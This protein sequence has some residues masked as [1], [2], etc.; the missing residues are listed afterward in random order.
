[1]SLLIDCHTHINDFPPSEISSVIERAYL[2][3]VEIIISARTTLQSS[4]A[5]V[6]LTQAHSQVYCG[7]GLHPMNLS[8]PIDKQTY[9]NLERL[10]VENPKVVCI[11]EIGLDFLPTSPKHEHQYQAFRNQIQLAKDLNKPI[12]FH[13]RESNPEVIQTLQRENANQVGG[14]FHYFQG[15]LNTANASIELGFYISFAKPLL[16]LPWL[17]EIAK[18]VPLDQIVVETDSAPQPWKKYRKN[19]TEPSHLPLVVSKLAELKEVPVETVISQ[20]TY[21]ISKLLNIDLPKL[22]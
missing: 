17:Q 10:A 5:C 12:I 3:G 20:T 19:W 18:K 9:Q 13:S 14:V 21:N 22:P 11:S 7:V 15:D 2:E 1:M 8:G 4:Q 16:T 6:E